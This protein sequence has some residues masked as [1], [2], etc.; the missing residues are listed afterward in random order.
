[1]RRGDRVGGWGVDLINERDM[2][3]ETRGCSCTEAST[4]QTCFPYGDDDMLKNKQTNKH[5]KPDADAKKQAPCQTR[6]AGLPP[7][8][9]RDIKQ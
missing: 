7:Q 3:L 8:R 4:I 5:S 9:K 1:M 2:S 6:E